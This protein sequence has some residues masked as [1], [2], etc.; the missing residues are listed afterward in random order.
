MKRVSL[1][2]RF[3]LA[4]PIVCLLSAGLIAES[5]NQP[6]SGTPAAKQ[7]LVGEQLLI[8]IKDGL[9]T[10]EDILQIS[11]GHMGPCQPNE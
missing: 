7:Q 3:V 8:A 10:K 5:N 11:V 1:L 4:V 6:A 2:L 9:A